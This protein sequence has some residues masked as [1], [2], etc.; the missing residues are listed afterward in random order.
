MKFIFYDTETTGTTVSFDQ[1][2]QF[3]A[4]LTNADFEVLDRFEAKC[5][6]LPWIVPSPG[7][8]LVTGITP[9]MIDDPQ[10]PTFD[11][12]I[13]S[14]REQLLAWSPAV[15]IG[16][17]T[18]RFDEP[19][20]QRALWQNLFPPYL[21]VTRGNS[22]FDVL[23][24]A[25]AIEALK[26][27]SLAWPRDS[28]GKVTFRLDRLAPQLGLNHIGAHDAEA[29][30]DATV[31]VARRLAEAFPELWSALLKRT[32]KPAFDAAFPLHEIALF[33]ERSA[34]A[35]R[36]WWGQRIDRQSGS[37]H[38]VFADISVDWALL[39][40][41]ARGEGAQR[42][43]LRHVRQV[44]LNRP[45]PVFTAA[46]AS[47]LLTL[48]MPPQMQLNSTFLQT[49][50]GAAGLAALS[51]ESQ[52]LALEEQREL[53][54]MIY[55]GF[56]SSSDEARMADFHVA[57]PVNRPGIAASFEDRRFRALATRMLFVSHPELLA[58]SEVDKVQR[59]IRSRLFPERE[60]EDYP[61]RSIRK[62]KAELQE[63][64]KVCEY[65]SAKLDE[66]EA[67]LDAFT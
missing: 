34:G 6:R 28:D 65:P 15:F 55:D 8:M 60:P 20:L 53:E 51:S 42:D 59:G 37:R 38:A 52:I 57:S 63:L 49:W 31:F 35:P 33:A 44:T 10:L 30:V 23:L 47:R 29:D 32:T 7:A 27:D 41:G 43:L 50:I 16:Y 12:F 58:P 9:Q 36:I 25:R 40:E 22:R 62:A 14:V 1:I 17:N 21:T 48:T 11:T 56:A 46:E 2:L 26:P 45:A 5:R 39:S 18:F 4:V 64:K 24:L 13:A 54:Q 3:G 19:L 67:W 61:W 66:I